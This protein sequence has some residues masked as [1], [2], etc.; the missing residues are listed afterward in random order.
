[1]IIR[2][3]GALRLGEGTAGV[4][5]EAQRLPKCQVVLSEYGRDFPCRRYGGGRERFVSYFR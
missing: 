4:Y 3:Y 2:N 5:G 1:M